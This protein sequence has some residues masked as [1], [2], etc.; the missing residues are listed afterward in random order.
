MRLG[1]IAFLLVAPFLAKA[2]VRDFD[3]LLLDVPLELTASEQGGVKRWT[4]EVSSLGQVSQVVTVMKSDISALD[5]KPTPEQF[6]A[7]HERAQ[8]TNR[9]FAAQFFLSQKTKL[10][11]MPF[12]LLTG[13]ML[14]PSAVGTAMPMYFNSAAFL[15]ASHAYEVIW[16]SRDATEYAAAFRSL[17]GAQWKQGSANH[18]VQDQFGNAGVYTIAGVPFGLMSRAPFVIR[19]LVTVRGEEEAAVAADRYEDEL[20]WKLDIRKRKTD[21]PPITDDEAARAMFNSLLLGEVTTIESETKDG[22]FTAIYMRTEAEGVIKA[23]VRRSGDWIAVLMVEVPTVERAKQVS[24]DRLR[25][26]T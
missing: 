17:R 25:T 20:T 18:P 26:G 14:G 21:A 19:P 3:G 8:R 4:G 10:A 7:M 12:L 5:Q 16:I 24:M 1:F 11:D 13:S 22:V 9:N 2:T 23:A 6:L 15:T